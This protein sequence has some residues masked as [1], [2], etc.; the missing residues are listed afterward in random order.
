MTFGP[1][2]SH[3]QDENFCFPKGAMQTVWPPPVQAPV[4]CV[5]L[6]AAS[7]CGRGDFKLPHF[8]ADIFY[9]FCLLFHFFFFFFS[10][11]WPLGPFVSIHTYSESDSPFAAFFILSRCYVFSEHAQ[12]HAEGHIVWPGSSKTLKYISESPANKQCKRITCI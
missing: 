6:T 12:T 10:F 5:I 8:T 4:L 9:P 7:C 2:A 11:Y 1:L 3:L